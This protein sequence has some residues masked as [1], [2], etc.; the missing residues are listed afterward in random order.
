MY[1]I[2]FFYSK[3]REIGNLWWVLFTG[4]VCGSTVA[5]E[6]LDLVI[7]L[8][9]Y[10]KGHKTKNTKNAE[11]WQQTRW[12]NTV[13]ITPVYMK[14]F[15][16]CR[17]RSS[18]PTGLFDVQM[19]ELVKQSINYVFQCLFNVSLTGTIPRVSF[20][21]TIIHICIYIYVY[22]YLVPWRLKV[23]RFSFI[24]L[25]Q[26]FYRTTVPWTLYENQHVRCPKST[27]V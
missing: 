24:F 3:W 16:P 17:R 15:Q 23:A 1:S 18:K 2:F 5:L 4:I 21:S 13:T 10:E 27:W 6:C 25:L 26:A 14:R 20:V 7:S 8:L 19:T 11:F 22:R 12:L 9:K